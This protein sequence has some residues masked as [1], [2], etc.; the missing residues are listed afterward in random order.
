MDV[1]AFKVVGGIG[2]ELGTQRA[3]MVSDSCIEDARLSQWAWLEASWV[4][5]SFFP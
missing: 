3:A 2:E 4:G 1:G 5:F